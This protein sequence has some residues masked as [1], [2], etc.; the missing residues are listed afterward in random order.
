MNKGVDEEGNPYEGDL[1]VAKKLY[2][3]NGFIG[4]FPG[5]GAKTLQSAIQKYEFFYFYNWVTRA[6]KSVLNLGKSDSLGVRAN[7]LVGYVSAVGTIFVTNPIEVAANRLQTGAD[8]GGLWQVSYT[9]I[10]FCGFF[11]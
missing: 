4:F 2:E 8:S 11:R 10:F 9:H 6:A 3:K 7:L 1:D 5:C